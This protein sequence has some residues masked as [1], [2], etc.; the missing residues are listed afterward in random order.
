MTNTFSGSIAMRSEVEATSSNGLTNVSDWAGCKNP[1]ETPL[2]IKQGKPT[3][4]PSLTREEQAAERAAWA[5]YEAAGAARSKG[6][7]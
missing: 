1:I 2:N 7:A 6:P 5:R 4:S 3:R